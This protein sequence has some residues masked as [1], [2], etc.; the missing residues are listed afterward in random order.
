MFY[1]PHLRSA[2]ADGGAA[3]GSVPVGAAA[4]S[5]ADDG[6][7]GGTAETDEL[8]GLVPVPA[9]APRGI[10]RRGLG[11]TRHITNFTP[12]VS[13]VDKAPGSSVSSPNRNPLGLGSWRF[14]AGVRCGR[15]RSRSPPLPANLI[16]ERAKIVTNQ[17]IR[18]GLPPGVVIYP[19]GNLLLTAA[20]GA[21]SREVPVDPPEGLQYVK[22][23]Q[24]VTM[25]DV[26]VI[27]PRLSEGEI[28]QLRLDFEKLR[29]TFPVRCTQPVCAT[30]IGPLR[31]IFQV[32]SSLIFCS[33]L[34]LGLFRT[35]SSSP[36]S[37]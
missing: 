23:H 27:R 13:L 10:L 32:I 5:I 8:A 20:A 36:A 16:G 1:S 4:A 17:E 21:S 15:W 9:L 12:G 22:F 29:M 14:H 33:P 19:S 24:E 34:L 28:K 2:T 18:A 3:V 30:K 6:G 35:T 11:A 37:C 25:N 31:E 26:K 7:D